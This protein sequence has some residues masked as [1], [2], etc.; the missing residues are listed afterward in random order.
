MAGAPELKMPG[1]ACCIFPD[2]A[3]RTARA[4]QTPPDLER[5]PHARLARGSTPAAAAIAVPPGPV[6]E[7]E[8]WPSCARLK[9]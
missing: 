4:E 2:R 9:N 7:E 8:A 5:T 1:P 6:H 3:P